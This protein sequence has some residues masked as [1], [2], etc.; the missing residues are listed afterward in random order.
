VVY[1][2]FAARMRQSDVI[3]SGEE[4][5]YQVMKC[6]SA[7]TIDS[8]AESLAKKEMG[9]ASDREHLL[10][11]ASGGMRPAWRRLVPVVPFWYW[12]SWP[13]NCLNCGEM[14]LDRGRGA[15]I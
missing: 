8:L 1:G 10:P 13:T 3:L 2:F 4:N 14:T 7:L 15:A 11:R 5:V 12:T 6:S 9:Q